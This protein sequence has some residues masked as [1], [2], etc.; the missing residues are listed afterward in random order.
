MEITVA[1]DAELMELKE[2]IESSMELDSL[3]TSLLSALTV[4]NQ[5]SVGQMVRLERMEQANALRSEKRTD[6][7]VLTKQ[8]IGTPQTNSFIHVA[9]MG[10]VDG[11]MRHVDNSH[12]LDPVLRRFLTQAGL[13]PKSLSSDDIEQAKEFAEKENLY[14]IYN[15]AKEKKRTETTE[16]ECKKWKITIIFHFKKE[17]RVIQDGN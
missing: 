14:T 7:K 4:L 17:I 12:L 1:A 13:D 6:K 2:Q 9:G 8:D 10:M 15:E 11:E 5:R 3:K 16:V